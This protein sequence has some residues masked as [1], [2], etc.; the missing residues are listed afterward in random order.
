[1][2]SAYTHHQPLPIG[3]ELAV[4]SDRGPHPRNPHRVTVAGYH[5][6]VGVAICEGDAADSDKTRARAH[7]RIA[8]EVS[9]LAAAQT[10]NAAAGVYAGRSALETSVIEETNPPLKPQ[11]T[12]IVGSL[13]T[14]VVTHWTV[15]LCWMGESVQAFALTGDMAV[16]GLI[17]PPSPKQHAIA[18]VRRQQV[19]REPPGGGDQD[20]R[21]LDIR[22]LLLCSDSL[23]LPLGTSDLTRI[24]RRP[25]PASATCAELI[26]AAKQRGALDP[27]T[28]AVVDL[29][30]RDATDTEPAQVRQNVPARGLTL[31]LVPTG[32]APAMH[33][34]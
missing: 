31:H 10:A 22:R 3:G 17:R 8:A 9:A 5:S 2:S 11:A 27:L 14:A 16:H 32:G 7:A 34:A 33:A 23:T 6:S 21:V 19:W 25:I 28:V 18:P 12:R 24:L 30:S 1:M 15:D 4:R 13:M 20:E 26:A 29:P